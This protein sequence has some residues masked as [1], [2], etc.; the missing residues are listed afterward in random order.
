M[1][2]EDEAAVELGE[3]VL[4]DFE[5]RDVEV[6]G[7]LVEDEQVG[8]LAHQA[9][10]EDA[11]LLTARQAAHGHLELFGS[12][13]EAPGP[14]RDVDAA[15]LPRDRV[16]L[17]RERAAQA[18]GR[19]EA[20]ALLLEPDDPQPIGAL[21]L[22]RVGWQRSRQEIEQRRLAAAVRADQADARAGRDDEVEVADQTPA[23]ERLRQAPRDQQPARP[24]LRR[25]EV[26]ARG[27]RD[28]ARAAV[29]QLVDEPGRL[30]DPSLGLGRACLGAPAQPLDLA[31]HGIG[32]RFL[33][34]RLPAQKLVAP[35]Q[36]V[37]VSSLGLEEAVRIGAV[38]L[39]HAR[40]HVLEEIAI[41]ADDEERARP[42][43]QDAF[44]PENAFHVEVIG[45]LVHQEDVR[46]G[47]QLA[48]DGE[49][50]LPAPRQRVDLR[51][52]IREPGPA[53]CLRDSAGP[54][55]LV[56]A[57]Q[58]RPHDVVD[59]AAA[60][61]DGV[62]G[63]VADTNAAANR[64]GTGV[65][66]RDAGENLQQRRLAGAIGTDEARLVAFEQS[67]RQ[68]V[69][70]RPGSEGLADGLTAEQERA[71]HPTLLLLLLRLLLLLAHAFAFR[72]GLTSSRR[73]SAD[74]SHGIATAEE[75]RRARCPPFGDAA[76][77]GC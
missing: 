27:G 25:H 63:H 42:V 67:E 54:V 20:A 75:R 68:T 62:L 10:D 23:A 5:G 72:H 6:V 59:R 39:Q 43:G 18:L 3:A 12:E 57:V 16:A 58:R 60:D 66:R 1:G 29:L 38:Q 50:L 71:G 35:R 77:A 73:V 24:A 53:E 55:L 11:G 9:R 32:Q 69:E 41:V 13:Q 65:G 56:D 4:E 46:C 28:P 49:P 17:G 8:G 48:R 34:G 61:E 30:L 52:R 14:G 19:I 15:A 40:G 21:D 47:R 74:Y 37:A 44:Q 22:T 26:D 76:T 36:E 33:V 2:D 31:A 64:A 7:G 45:G 51:A 70:E